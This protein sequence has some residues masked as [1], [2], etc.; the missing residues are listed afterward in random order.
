LNKTVTS[1]LTIVICYSFLRL[2]KRCDKNESSANKRWKRTQVEKG[3][4][5]NKEPPTN[6]PKWA[7]SDEW[8]DIIERRENP[9]GEE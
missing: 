7:L 3:A 1:I 4:A 6:T 8:K 9:Q 2:D 5:I